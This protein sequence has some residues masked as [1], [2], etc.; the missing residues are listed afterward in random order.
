MKQTD[1]TWVVTYEPADR[2]ITGVTL[3]G[4]PLMTKCVVVEQYA[5]HPLVLKLEVFVF[6]DAF[7]FA[8]EKKLDAQEEQA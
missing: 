5:G 2:K 7:S 4:L 8:E 1:N 6:N 3:N